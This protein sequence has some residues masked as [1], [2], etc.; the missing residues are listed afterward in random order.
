[1][2]ERT[3]VIETV[4]PLDPAPT[5]VRR[6]ST[7]AMPATA[8]DRVETVAYDPYDA[9]RQTAYRAT[10]LIYWVFGLIEGLILVRFVLKALGA[11]P[12]AGFAAFIYGITAPLVLPFQNLF[13]TPQ[14]QGSVLELNS[15]VALIVYAVIA[16]LLAKLVWV[17]MG[18][19]RSAVR[20]HSSEIDARV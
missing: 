18:E 1:M 5:E 3:D 15:L 7:T 6:V 17:V 11:N 2:Q 8:V 16:W 12:D 20:T 10:Q 14:A 9:R 19:T 4:R 13:G